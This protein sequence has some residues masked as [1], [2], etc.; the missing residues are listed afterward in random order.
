MWELSNEPEPVRGKRCTHLALTLPHPTCEMRV[1]TQHGAARVKVS[2]AKAIERG[3]CG[4]AGS[5]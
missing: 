2:P 1:L 3:A 4:L 5:K